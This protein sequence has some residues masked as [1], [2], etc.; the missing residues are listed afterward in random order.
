M[1]VTTLL[2]NVKLVDLEAGSATPGAWLRLSD[3]LIAD[4][5]R[6]EVS[7]GDSRVE[8]LG[9]AYLIPGLWDTHVHMSFER[10][11]RLLHLVGIPPPIETVA[12]RTLRCIE[13]A[14]K[15]VR[16]G[17]TG[18][19]SV[20]EA[21]YIDCAAKALFERGTIVGPRIVPSGY[22]LTTTSG[23]ITGDPVALALDGPVAFRK[24]VRD[25]IRHGAELIKLNISGG[26]WGPSWDD[27]YTIVEA[28]DEL[29]ALF[30]TAKQRNLPV[31]THA[32]AAGSAKL[33]AERGTKSIEHGYA[34]DEEAIEVMARAGVTYVP[35]L[36]VAQFGAGHVVDQYEKEYMADFVVPPKIREKATAI[37]ERHVWGFQA[38]RK[39]GI[40]IACGS[41]LNPLADGAKLELAALV[42][43]G[44]TPR[45]ALLAATR[46]SAELSGYGD[47]T[48]SIAV[49][50][51]A[52]L[53]ALEV[54]PLDDIYA[55]RHVAGVWRAGV[56]V[57]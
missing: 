31:A 36:A 32:G 1:P 30:T 40:T 23:H 4:V 53:V 38:A 17:I 18:L 6:G 56:R 43:F 48:G 37:A 57:T 25:N 15:A 8:D 45:E 49:G 46:T 41:D 29:D 24:A 27:V 47:I 50:K 14:V 21:D 26:V 44:M 16:A 33:A 11:L 2:T 51:A 10:P 19:R 28:E 52:D 42:R 20:G 22:F 13:A 3:G 54:D 34:L 55:I 39:A 12:E 9:G 5:G 7:A 35:T